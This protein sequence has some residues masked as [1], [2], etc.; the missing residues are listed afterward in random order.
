MVQ[1][2]ITDATLFEGEH[3]GRLDG[4]AEKETAIAA[5]AIE[6]ADGRSNMVAEKDEE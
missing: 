3:D 1:S 2:E 6:Q 5:K 4:P